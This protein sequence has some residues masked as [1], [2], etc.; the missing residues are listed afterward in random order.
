M[1]ILD[2][3]TETSVLY[4][5]YVAGLLLTYIS[6][7][8]APSL[9][10]SRE[11][12]DLSADEQRAEDLSFEAA[13]VRAI[14]PLQNQL[15][16][17][18]FFAS[19]GFAIVSAIF[20]SPASTQTRSQPFLELWHP[21]VLWRGIVYSVL[22]CTAKLAVGLP[23]LF[24]PVITTMPA[25]TSRLRHRLKALYH[26]T[27]SRL[28]NHSPGDVAIQMTPSHELQRHPNCL[29][30]STPN[31]SNGV[32]SVSLWYQI[33]ASVPAS[34]FMG[35]AMVSRGEIGLLIAQ[36]AR[37]GG[38]ASDTSPGDGSGL[39]GDEAF[40]ICIWAILLC[41]LVGPIGVGVVVRRWNSKIATGIWT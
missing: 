5:A 2:A 15:F 12:M 18:L 25:R 10:S 8:P 20:P 37:T 1:L 33:I 38:D 32:H 11:S 14:G 13:F 22:M 21:T 7:P 28:F 36:L 4:G 9:S 26:A 39:L 29:S 30:P 24:Y 3:D 27:T 17:P 19:I 41:T 16:L 31:C 23:V 40:L 6:K 34:V 35:V